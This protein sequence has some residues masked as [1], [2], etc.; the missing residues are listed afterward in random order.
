MLTIFYQFHA[1]GFTVVFNVLFLDDMQ[2]TKE[3]LQCT[4]LLD[5]SSIHKAMGHWRSG[6]AQDSPVV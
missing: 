2:R 4:L 6:S 3:L 1:H 5:S